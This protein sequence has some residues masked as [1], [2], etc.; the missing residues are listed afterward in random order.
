MKMRNLVAC[1]SDGRHGI[2]FS[3]FLNVSRGGR[4]VHFWFHRVARNVERPE[5]IPKQTFGVVCLL[6]LAEASPVT[7]VARHLAFSGLVTSKEL[8]IQSVDVG[9][10]KDRIWKLTLG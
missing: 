6:N 2:L 10:G 5:A 3:S 9:A 4:L 1:R 8:R 7:A